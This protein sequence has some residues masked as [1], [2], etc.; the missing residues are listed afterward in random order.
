MNIVF[1]AG[2]GTEVGKT[3]TLVQ[4]VRELRGRGRRLSVRKPA[5]SFEP[6]ELGAT[7]AE[8][9][10]AASGE[11]PQSVCPAH[12]WYETPMAPCLAATQLGRPAFT[13]RELAVEVTNRGDGR[14]AVR[15]RRRWSPVTAGRRW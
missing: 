9:L 4:L 15:R 14:G 8:L 10:A 7:D 6:A 2:T 12:R 5:Q 3:W 13:T 1:V 11:Q